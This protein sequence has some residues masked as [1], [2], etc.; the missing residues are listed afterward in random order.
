MGLSPYGPARPENPRDL[1]KRS[2]SPTDRSSILPLCRARP[3]DWRLF[4]VRRT[5][6]P[7]PSDTTDL[8]PSLPRPTVPLLTRLFGDSAPSIHPS[9]ALPHFSSGGNWKNWPRSSVQ[10]SPNGEA[11]R[12]E[13]PA[14]AE[15][16]D[17]N[18]QTNARPT[19]GAIS[20]SL[21]VGSSSLG[22]LVR[23]LSPARLC[24]LSV[25]AARRRRRA[26]H[27]TIGRR[28]RVRSRSRLARFRS[29]C[30][31]LAPSRGTQRGPSRRRLV[32]RGRERGQFSDVLS[33]S[34]S[35]PSLPPSSVGMSRWC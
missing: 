8:L 28:P 31:S 2:R 29:S 34:S 22:I 4:S 21:K 30:R 33:P 25:A 19:A 14:A 18:G 26:L 5:N 12:E 17:G 20:I 7:P 23:P 24:R 6:S 10:I 13:R 9:I 32:R 27:T 1:C 11:R 15:R 3:A 35:S 16:L